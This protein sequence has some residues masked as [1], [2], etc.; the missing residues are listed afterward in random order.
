MDSK[1]ICLFHKILFSPGKRKKM[2]PKSS[3]KNASGKKYPSGLT[4]YPSGLTKYSVKIEQTKSVDPEAQ[5]NEIFDE[6][7]CKLVNVIVKSM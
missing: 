1:D 4:K 2:P 6:T 7:K 3:S 5:K